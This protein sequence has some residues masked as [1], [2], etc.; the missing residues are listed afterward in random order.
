MTI[1]TTA[2]L[3]ERLNARAAA[4]APGL[5]EAFVRRVRLIEENLGRIIK[6]KGEGI[7]MVL[8]ALM[9]GGHIL[10]EDVPGT[11]KTTL[12]KALARS[13][14][15]E[16]R[17]IQFTPDLLPADVTGTSFY[18]PRD[19]SFTFREGPVFTNILLADE[20]NRTSPRT[21]AALLEVMS[22]GTVTVEGQRRDLAPPF[23]VVATQ[24]PS[25]YAGTYPLPEAQLD[26]F[27]V[28][29]TLGYPDPEHELEVLFTHND[30]HPLN[31]LQPVL[32]T[33]DVL[34][35]QAAVRT[36]RVERAVAEYILRIVDVTRQDGRLRLGISPRGSLALYRM[37][38][39]RAAM[40]GRDFVLPEDVRSLAV[41]VLA[42]R[43]Q[44]DTK[45]RYGG[46]MPSHII[47]E[48]LEKTPLPR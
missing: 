23:L 27:A 35:L 46:L 16:F 7:A 36:V 9:A 28:R 38:Q 3:P 44:L 18:N 11:G 48:A 12:A 22:E 5:S 21:Q 8:T 39:A 40:A 1:T 14:D 43:L 34:E 4:S 25:D 29:I 2:P 20:I 15:G 31:D 19:G 37:A 26:R 32:T 10:L 17:R 47:E 33:A 13:I 42:H 41:P 45:S 24:N 30:H 6:G